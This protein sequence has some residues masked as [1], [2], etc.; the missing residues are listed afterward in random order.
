M[1]RR[2]K[3]HAIHTLEEKR[4][5]HLNIKIDVH[6]GLIEEVQKFINK[7]VNGDETP[8]SECPLS[9]NIK[10]HTKK[11]VSFESCQEYIS[12]MSSEIIANQQ[13][14]MELTVFESRKPI[15]FVL[16]SHDT[17]R[18]KLNVFKTDD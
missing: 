3:L 5:I 8:W 1:P 13:K 4:L 7:K 14:I 6:T 10:N 16:K 11:E 17:K 15:R 12:I 2:N 9:Y 18:R